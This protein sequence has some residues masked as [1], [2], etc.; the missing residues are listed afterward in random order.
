M[1]PDN[2]VISLKYSDRV[3]CDDEYLGDL[4]LNGLRPRIKIRCE[5]PKVCNLLTCPDVNRTAK[6]RMVLQRALRVEDANWLL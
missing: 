6:P 2:V 5:S 1:N 4:C 3:L